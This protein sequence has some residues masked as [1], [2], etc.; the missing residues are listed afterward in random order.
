MFAES[1]GDSFADTD[2][3]P[4]DGSTWYEGCRAR[5]GQ[6]EPG[7]GQ[8]AHAGAGSFATSVRPIGCSLKAS[9]RRRREGA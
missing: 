7:E 9:C 1:S 5:G 2:Q 4:K 6:E 3:T 8:E